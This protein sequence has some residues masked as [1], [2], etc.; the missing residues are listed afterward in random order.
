MKKRNTGFILIVLAMIIY[1]LS[2]FLT[3]SPI[4][5]KLF[6]AINIVLNAVGA[7]I[8]L[9]YIREETKKRKS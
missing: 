6:F 3:L 9:L 4:M 8:L 5:W 7:F 1:I 2:K